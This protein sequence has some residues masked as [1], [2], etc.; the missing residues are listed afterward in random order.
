MA[1]RDLGYIAAVRVAHLPITGLVVVF[2]CIRVCEL[3][4]PDTSTECS[5]V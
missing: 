4:W 5:C 2:G 3:E 1:R